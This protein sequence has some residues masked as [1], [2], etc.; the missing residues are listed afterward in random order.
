LNEAG[1]PSFLRGRLPL[2]FRADELLAVA[3]IPGLDSPREGG[4]RLSW[5][6]PTNDPGLS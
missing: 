1:V 5:S 3:N 6:P 4:W 2:L